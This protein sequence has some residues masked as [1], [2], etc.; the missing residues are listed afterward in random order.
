MPRE[1]GEGALIA[2]G[3]SVLGIGT[4]VGGSIRLPSAFC[5]IVGIK[6]TA[7]RIC[8]KGV[9]SALPGAVG[10][11]LLLGIEVVLRVYQIYIL[12]I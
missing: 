3:G 7:R 9:V 10:C 6:P 4:D 8:N 11:E 5:G 12:L 1:G 2:G